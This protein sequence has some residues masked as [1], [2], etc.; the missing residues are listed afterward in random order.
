ML[1]RELCELHKLTG[2][3]DGDITGPDGVQPEKEHLKVLLREQNIR[4]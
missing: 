4:I 3:E 2:Y 1:S